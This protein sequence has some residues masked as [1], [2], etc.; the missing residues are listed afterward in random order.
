M[1]ALFSKIGIFKIIVVI[2][3]RALWKKFL[4][5]VLK[6]VAFLLRRAPA[7]H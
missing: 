5:N 6:H 2:S 7:D 3:F 4:G 1:S